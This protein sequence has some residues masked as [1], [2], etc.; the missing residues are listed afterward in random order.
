M[1]EVGYA[2]D[3]EG[4]GHCMEWNVEGVGHCMEW[5]VEGVGCIVGVRK[6]SKTSSIFWE[7]KIPRN[8][9]IFFSTKYTCVILWARVA[10]G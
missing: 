4:V 3:F 7:K 8:V 1:H 2:S 6:I 5:N 10:G 9:R